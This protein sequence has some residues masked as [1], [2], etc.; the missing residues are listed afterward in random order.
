MKRIF[1]LF[2]F[3][4]VVMKL[5][6][7]QSANNSL[8]FLANRNLLTEIEDDSLRSEIFNN[9]QEYDIDNTMVIQAVKA[10]E[11]SGYTQIRSQMV[12]NQVRMHDLN[13]NHANLNVK[14]RISSFLGYRLQTEM[15]SSPQLL[16]AYAE[17]RFKDYFNISVGQQKVPFSL[18]NLTESNHLS[19]IDRSQVV[20]AFNSRS[21][22]VADNSSRDVGIQ[23]KGSLKRKNRILVDYRIGVF[24]GLGIKVFD[25]YQDKDVVA[26]LV[27]HPIAGLALGGD[28]YNGVGKFGNTEQTANRER[29]RWGL[30]LNYE[31]KRISLRSEYIKGKDADVTRDG[32]YVQAGYYILL[33]KLQAILKYD[34]YN[35]DLSLNDDSSSWYI[36][37][38]T[39]NF[40]STTRIQAGYTFIDQQGPGLKNNFL[41]VQFQ[42][43][44]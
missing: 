24:N 27:F 11:I 29:S 38:L 36:I 32:Y 16:E 39:Y 8:N 28:Y 21:K 14:G 44:F 13:I 43:G 9:I 30:E 3:L 6:F 22:N 5:S 37:G 33:Q 23:V 40:N 1:I 41:A 42:I 15:A 10:I 34:T 18:E 2:F 12:N 35:D 4:F 31:K 7:S 19:L 26:R 25:N 17:V 20:S